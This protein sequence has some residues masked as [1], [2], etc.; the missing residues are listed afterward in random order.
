MN[1]Q[2]DLVP[3]PRPLPQLRQPAQRILDLRPPRTKVFEIVRVLASPNDEGHGVDSG[4][5]DRR[6]NCVGVVVI[7]QV[8]DGQCDI[9]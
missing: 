7:V 6:Q 4:R 9:S 8:P 1:V 5:N 2:D 3:T